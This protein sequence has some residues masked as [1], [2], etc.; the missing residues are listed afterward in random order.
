MQLIVAVSLC[1]TEPICTKICVADIIT[2]LC[3]KFRSEIFRGYDIILY[4]YA[5]VMPWLHVK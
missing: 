4:Y 1:V 5:M 3:A 2:T